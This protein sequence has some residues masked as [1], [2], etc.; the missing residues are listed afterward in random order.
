MNRKPIFKP[1]ICIH[2]G[3]ECQKTFIP[4]G[5]NQILC[6]KCVVDRR[7]SDPSRRSV[8]R[9]VYRELRKEKGLCVDCPNSCRKGK[10][11]CLKCHKKSLLR[12]KD[13][14]KKNPDLIRSWH[15]QRVYGITIDQYRSIISQQNNRCAICR[16]DFISLNRAPDTDHCHK[17]NRVR[18]IL[19][20]KCN[21]GLAYIEDMFFRKNALQY[22]EEK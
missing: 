11:L 22:L 16:R 2:N 13:K 20:H 5:P 19:C 7:K 4:N 15:R 3:P 17:T 18:G 14:R 9:Q 1:R 21:V 6:K 12:Q 8:P 10:W